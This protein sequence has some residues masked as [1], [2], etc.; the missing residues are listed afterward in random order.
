MDKNTFFSAKNTDLI[1][2]ICRD[3]V[4]KKTQYNIDT[5][6]KYFK[7]FGEIMKI[8]HKH[9]NDTNDL[10]ILNNKTIGKTIPYL[11]G[12]IQKK[13]LKEKPL[14]PNNHILNAPGI[15]NDSIRNDSIR[16]D[17]ISGNELPVSF[18]GNPSN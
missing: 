1:Y 16:N 10:T 9:S 13:N 11:V 18:R 5:N 12:E 6:K 8:V 3:D 2:T 7:T 15:R 17:S 14:I 4:L